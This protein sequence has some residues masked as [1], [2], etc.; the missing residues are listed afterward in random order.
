M[1][2]GG[3]REGDRR[4]RPQADPLTPPPDLPIHQ[5]PRPPLRLPG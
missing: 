5:D 3:R 2:E 1:E 4:T